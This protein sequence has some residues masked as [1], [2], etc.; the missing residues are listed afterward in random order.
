MST[1]GLNSSNDPK[2]PTFGC[3]SQSMKEFALKIPQ[4]A[5]FSLVSL[6]Q[7]ELEMVQLLVNSQSTP[8]SFFFAKFFLSYV[9]A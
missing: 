3:F 2:P 9:C 4:A 6:S 7:M 8:L 5:G 1:K